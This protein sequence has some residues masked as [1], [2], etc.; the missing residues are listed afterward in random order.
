MKV[1]VY[2]IAKNEANQVAPYTDSCCDADL[3]VTAHSGSFLF[4]G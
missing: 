4:E 2:T 3:A 1:A